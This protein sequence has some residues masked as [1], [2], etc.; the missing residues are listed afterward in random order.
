MASVIA[1]ITARRLFNAYAMSFR[2]AGL[3]NIGFVQVFATNLEQS[4][5]PVTAI[6][7]M[8]GHKDLKT[9]CGYLETSMESKRQ[10]QDML[11]KQL[12]LA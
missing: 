7:E 4:G 1:P 8:L 5:A 6:Q 9:T 2:S 10:A 12:G 3:P 11:S